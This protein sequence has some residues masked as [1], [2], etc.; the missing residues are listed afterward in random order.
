MSYDGEFSKFLLNIL[1]N[2]VGLSIT[3]KSTYFKELFINI[4]SIFQNFLYII[5]ALCD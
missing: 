2:M 5:C 4:V 3:A 1:W